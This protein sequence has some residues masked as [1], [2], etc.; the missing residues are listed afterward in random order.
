MIWAPASS[1]C[2]CSLKK[3]GTR[4]SEHE[5]TW[6]SKPVSLRFTVEKGFNLLH[7]SKRV[8]TKLHQVVRN[9]TSVT[10]FKQIDTN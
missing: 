4:S 3:N 7:A 9:Q 5:S 6:S 1:L 8:I 10:D 2:I